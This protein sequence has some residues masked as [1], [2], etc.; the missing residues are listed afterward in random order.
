MENFIFCALYGVKHSF[1]KMI[2]SG[3][4]GNKGLP[5]ILKIDIKGFAGVI[6]KIA[7]HCVHPFNYQVI[8]KKKQK[9]NEKEKK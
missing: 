6:F 1:S 4:C 9:Q 2:I 5:I 3:K 8:N 7:F